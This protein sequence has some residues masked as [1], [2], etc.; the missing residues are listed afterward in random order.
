M[1]NYTFSVVAEGLENID[2]DVRQFKNELIKNIVSAL[3]SVMDDARSHLKKHID[4]DVYSK[5]VYS[6]KVYKRRSDDNSWGTPLN[7]MEANTQVVSP[8]GGNVGG[9]LMVTTTLYYHPTGE[10]TVNKWSSTT[11]TPTVNNVDNDD[12]IARIEKKDPAYNWGQGEVPPRPFWQKFIT[13]MV[14]NGELEKLFV[15]AMKGKDATT[16]ADGQ[17]YEQPLDRE[18]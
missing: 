6:P 4:E 10:H 18:Y 8:S 13:E 5:S 2:E 12:L 3:P 11:T 16:V 1:P 7:N 14:D 9:Q 15:D 17:I